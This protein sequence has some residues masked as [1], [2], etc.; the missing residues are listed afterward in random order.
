MYELDY[1]LNRSRDPC[2][3]LMTFL[4]ISCFIEA[5]YALEEVDRL[6]NRRSYMLG[7]LASNMNI[8][9]LRSKLAR[10]FCSADRRETRAM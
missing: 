1:L 4:Q 9:H 6:T 2:W 8:A 7:E 5:K 3:T 10:N